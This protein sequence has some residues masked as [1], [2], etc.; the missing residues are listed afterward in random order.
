MAPEAGFRMEVGR[1]ADAWIRDA[2]RALTQGFLLLFDYGHEAADLCSHTHA[3]G[4]LMAYS[5]HTADARH[6]LEAPGEC[7]LTAHVNLTAVRRAAESVDLAGIGAV[8]QTYFLNSLGIAANLHGG[9]DVESIR[10]RLAA[11]SL[12]LPGGLG[13]AIKVLAFAKRLESPV[14]R[15]VTSGRLT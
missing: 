4:T 1:A 10:R 14:I 11:K 15:G 9:S 8:D 2:G 3:L 12:L 7:D 6:W 5:R 13:S